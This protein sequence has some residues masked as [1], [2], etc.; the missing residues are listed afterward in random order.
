[1]FQSNVRIV[2]TRIS[3]QPPVSTHLGLSSSP[4]QEDEPVNPSTAVPPSNTSGVSIQSP[5]GSNGDLG[6]QHYSVPCIKQDEVMHNPTAGLPGDNVGL[7]QVSSS[8]APDSLIKKQKAGGDIIP[9]KR[10]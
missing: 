10:P 7:S 1:M 3:I 8:P 6:S 9:E 4:P 2:Q 5:G